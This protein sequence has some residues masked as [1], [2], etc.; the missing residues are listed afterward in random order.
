[1]TDAK[2][3]PNVQAI[4][5]ELTRLAEIAAGMLDGEQVKAIITEQAMHYVAN[6][7]PKHRF[8]QGDYYDVEHEPFLQ[9][10]KFLTR[11]ERLGRIP[12]SGSVWVP[13]PGCEAVTVAVQNGPHHRYYEFGQ[14]SL[15]TPPEMKQV[16]QTGEVVAAPSR[17]GDRRVTVLGPVRD[18]LGDVVA[19]V[20]LT[21][22]L[23]VQGPAWS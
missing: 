15:D 5:D 10:K 21:A 3:P 12:L 14:A 11:L 18:S 20:E 13:V 9:T 4:C 2:K 6:P 17:P 8:L 23:D 19:V 22:P 1:M 7:D 16:L